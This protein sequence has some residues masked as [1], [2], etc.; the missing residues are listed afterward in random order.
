M[1]GNELVAVNIAFSFK[2]FG[3]D[4]EEREGKSL[5]KL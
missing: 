1:G 3:S 5:R 2:N 4:R